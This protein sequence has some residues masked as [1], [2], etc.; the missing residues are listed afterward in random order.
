[1]AGEESTNKLPLYKKRKNLTRKEENNLET[2]RNYLH[3]EKTN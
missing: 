1:M 2:K 3:K